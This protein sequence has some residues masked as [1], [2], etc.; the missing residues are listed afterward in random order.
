MELLFWSGEENSHSK[1]LSGRQLIHFENVF[2]YICVSS[3]PEPAYLA[4]AEAFPIGPG[5]RKR[6]RF[7]VSDTSN[8]YWSC[9]NQVKQLHNDTVRQ[10]NL[11]HH[12]RCDLMQE[13]GNKS[14]LRETDNQC[15]STLP[16]RCWLSLLMFKAVRH[17]CHCIGFISV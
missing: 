17:Y 13:L 15:A 5:F 1:V 6:H 8:W 11:P 3:M 10:T 9:Y 7:P 14:S 2:W 4:V 12:S 16:P